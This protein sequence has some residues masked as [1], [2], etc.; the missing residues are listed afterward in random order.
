[1]LSLLS[2]QPTSQIVNLTLVKGALLN[3]CVLL[4]ASRLSQ[5]ISTVTS[6]G[7]SRK[8]QPECFT[9]K[10]TVQHALSRFNKVTAGLYRQPRDMGNVSVFTS[11]YNLL[12]SWPKKKQLIHINC[13]KLLHGAPFNLVGMSCLSANRR[14]L[15]T[16]RFT[17][18]VLCVNGIVRWGK[19]NRCERSVALS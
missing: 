14:W 13:C 12:T 16:T 11:R 8:I 6:V 17:L 2:L 4:E 9:M 15:R 1:M 7:L 10:S 19:G 3:F 5:W 18:Y